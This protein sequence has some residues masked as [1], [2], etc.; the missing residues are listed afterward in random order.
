MNDKRVELMNFV[1]L[2]KQ[3][4]S[5]NLAAVKL[6]EL[7]VMSAAPLAH[8]QFH[9]IVFNKTIP[10]QPLCPTNKEKREDQR[11]LHS[12]SLFIKSIDERLACLLSLRQNQPTRQFNENKD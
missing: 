8:R 11:R 6:I 5:I 10:F 3:N 2:T 9:S 1:E 7:L 12:T 4:E